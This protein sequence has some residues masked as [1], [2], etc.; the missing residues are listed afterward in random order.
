LLLDLISGY[1]YRPLRAFAT[2]LLVVGAFASK[3]ALLAY[4]GM[5]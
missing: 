1:G 5:T 3:C 4:F 2:Y